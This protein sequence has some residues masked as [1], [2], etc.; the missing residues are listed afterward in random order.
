MEKAE[1]KQALLKSVDAV[2]DMRERTRHMEVDQLRS[3]LRQSFILQQIGIRP[4]L[5][6]NDSGD[7]GEQKRGANPAPRV[8]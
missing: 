6:E 2:T 5:V 8:P 3:A 7:G 1:L 4:S